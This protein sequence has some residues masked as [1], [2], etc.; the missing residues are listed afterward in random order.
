MTS[1]QPKVS[2]LDDNRFGYM[3]VDL[4]NVAVW[5]CEGTYK[6]SQ[7]RALPQA[8]SA[9]VH[10][11]AAR[12]EYEPFQIVLHP[13]VPLQDVKVSISPLARCAGGEPQ[14]VIGAENIEVAVVEY[15]PV[16]TPTDDFGSLGDYP[17]PLPL[18]KEPFNIPAGVN[19][20]LWYTLYVPKETPAGV[21]QG[22]VIIQPK[23]APAIEVPL[24]LRVFDFTLPDET[25]TRTAYGVSLDN[26]WHQLQTP[27]QFKQV[28]DLYMQNCRQH[29]ISPYGP[30]A[31]A[32][33]KWE[34][35]GEQVSVDFT[36]FDDAMS[37][38]LDDFRFNGFRF[39]ILPNELGG[40]ARFTP[41]YNALYKQLMQP[42]IAHLK[43]KGWLDKA[44][45]YWIDEPSPERYDYVKDGCRLLKEACP[46]LTRLL[47]VNHDNAPAPTFY[48]FVDLWV[49]IF[50]RFDPDRAKQRQA[51]GEE[52]WWY[53][54]TGP[55]A[56]YPNNFIDHPAINH[57]IRAWMGE[58][59]GTDGELYWS[60]TY[61]RQKEGKL[62][63]PWHDGMSIASAGHGWGN[64]DGMLLY[65]PVKEPPDEPV[66]R[67]PIN[68][69]RWELLREGLEDREYFWL[70]KNLLNEAK[71]QQAAAREESLA[72]AIIK[73]KAALAD[74]MSLVTSLTEFETEPA[75]LYAARLQVA[76]AI[77]ELSRTL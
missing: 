45:C 53:V 36:E 12:N 25:H 67:G 10:I 2:F 16:T 52:V 32:P 19:Q 13:K 31:F 11:S 23:D 60:V 3:L 27:E 71:K 42:I 51:L 68:S 57:R 17:D 43:D 72:D 22:R 24:Q 18:L 64:G 73:G 37:R 35:Q 15:V 34:L 66:L 14:A 41:A 4:P 20:P 59:F 65:P 21:Y 58:K 54:C 28:W 46:G 44:Y 61:Y 40:H 74:A 76:E 77:E 50:H 9:T 75:K 39:V 47:T 49:P 30:H 48:G 70:L 26:N 38:Y 33:I 69:V 8:K 1:T 29:R 6:V 55:K 56:P 7:Q 62:R 63:N 5:W